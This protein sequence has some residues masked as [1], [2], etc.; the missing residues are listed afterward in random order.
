MEMTSSVKRAFEC[1]HRAEEQLTIAYTVLMN[2]INKRLKESPEAREIRILFSIVDEIDAA[3]SAIQSAKV[4]IHRNYK[5]TLYTNCCGMAA[6]PLDDS[7][8]VRC[9]KCGDM[10]LLE[11]NDEDLEEGI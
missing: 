3:R 4:L 1:T 8:A 11:T 7:G 10:A 2:K 5:R 6:Q 9:P